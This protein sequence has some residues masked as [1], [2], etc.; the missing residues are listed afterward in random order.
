VVCGD[1]LKTRASINR[2]GEVAAD[3]TLRTLLLQVLYTIRSE[4][5]L[6]ERLDTTFF[7]A[8]S[9]GSIWTRQCGT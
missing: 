1:V 6:M 9:W 7:I 2:A 8:G 4:R 3:A 5:Q